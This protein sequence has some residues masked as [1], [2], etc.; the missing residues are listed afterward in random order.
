MFFYFF[1]YFFELKKVSKNSF[2]FYKE[3]FTFRLTPQKPRIN[4]ELHAFFL[5]STLDFDVE[6]NSIPFTD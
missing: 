4:V 6:R 5:T 3:L 2:Q 1:R